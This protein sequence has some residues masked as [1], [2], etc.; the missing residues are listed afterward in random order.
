MS[1]D[2]RAAIG[3]NAAAAAAAAAVAA[4]AVTAAV[5]VVSRCLRRLEHR[6]K[7]NSSG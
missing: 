1:F 4:A 5:A 2:M 7:Y 6:R 3:I